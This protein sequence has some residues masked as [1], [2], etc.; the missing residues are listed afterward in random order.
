MKWL[1]L[2]IGVAAMILLA[3][4]SRCTSP[5]DDS[6]HVFPLAQGNSWDY[7]SESL[8][9]IAIEDGEAVLDTLDS[10]YRLEVARRETILDALAF[11]RVVETWFPSSV[12][13]RQR[14]HY[15][16]N[17]DDGLYLY[18]STTG[19]YVGY[20]GVS[21]K[22]RARPLALFHGEPLECLWHHMNALGDPGMWSSLDDSLDV[23]DPPLRSY[24]YPLFVGRQWTYR[25]PGHPWAV[26]K[27]VVGQTYVSVP[28]G[29]Y[30]CHIIQWLIDF[31]DEDGEWDDDTE[32]F[33]FVYA[34]QLVKRSLTV[35]GV[36]IYE[37]NNPTPVDTLDVWEDISLTAVDV[38]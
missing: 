2:M 11:F 35:R 26:D 12:E 17:T 37:G 9:V 4:C 34:G 28:A 29:T 19:S 3:S 15:Y 25:E 6:C 38:H 13:P 33:D 27:R 23:W 1:G 36:L 31:R 30:R 10:S 24:A 32:W 18:A 20:P 21:P 7:S 16:L 22:E 5:S 8:T 14:A